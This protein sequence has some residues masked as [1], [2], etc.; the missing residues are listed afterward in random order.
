MP[1]S[2]EKPEERKPYVKPEI[3]HEL[4]LE[5]RAGSPN[6]PDPLNPFGIDPES[7]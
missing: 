7:K 4:D 1:T 2:E 5:T 6:L 3:I